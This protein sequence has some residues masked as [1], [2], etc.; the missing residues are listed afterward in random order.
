MTYLVLHGKLALALRRTAEL[1]RV[2]K[3]V[4]QSDFCNAN[5]LFIADLTVNDSTSPLIKSTDDST[6]GRSWSSSMKPKEL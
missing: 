3:H 2:A 6:Y 1:T 5:E 4:I